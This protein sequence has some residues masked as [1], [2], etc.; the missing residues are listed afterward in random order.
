[1]PM[2]AYLRGLRARVGHDL[3]MVPGVTAVVLNEEGEVLLHRSANDG[4]WYLVGG[5]IDPGEQPADAA[6]RE[7]LE[8]A[9]VEVEPAR[10][11]AVYT[12]EPVTYPNGDVVMYVAMAFLCRPVRRGA[13]PYVADDESLDVRYFRPDA[14]PEGLVPLHRR[15]V[16]QALRGEEK[17]HF[18]RAT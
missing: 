9:G 17:A 12:E 14:L 15:Q 16:E 6:A 8:E 13:R 7:V 4:R 10:L 18:W 2:S 3:V 1:M 11:V 5:A